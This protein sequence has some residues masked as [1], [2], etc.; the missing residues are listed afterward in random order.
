MLATRLAERDDDVAGRKRTGAVRQPDV[1][2]A[3]D[4][5]ERDPVGKLEFARGRPGDSGTGGD[6]RS[7]H[8]RHAA[9]QPQQRDEVAGGHLLLH[10]PGDELG[11]RDDDVDA[12]PPA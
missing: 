5:R 2:R 7:R 1:I 9:A 12:R 3:D 8:H 10:Q 4:R 6:R 11:G